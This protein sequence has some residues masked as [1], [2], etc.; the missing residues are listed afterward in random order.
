MEANVS[1]TTIFANINSIPIPNGTNFKDWKENISIVLGCMDLDLA[2]RIEQPAPLTDE[3]SLHDMRNFEKWDHSNHMSLMIIKPGIPEAFR[4]A[5][6]EGIT[7][8]NEFL[9]EIEKHFTKND[10]AKT[11]TLLQRLISMKY[12]SKGNI[13]EYIMDISHIVSKLKGLKLELFDDLLVH[14]ASIPVIDQERN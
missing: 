5:V 1:T 14:L 11:S 2:L 4:G 6:S 13:M 10:K 7:N 8:V 3:S 9:V 12:K